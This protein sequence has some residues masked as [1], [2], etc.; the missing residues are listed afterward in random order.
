M[1]LRAVTLAALAA[2]GSVPA[3]HAQSLPAEP[4]SLGD[5]RLVIGAEFTAT[6][7]NKDKGYFNY[8]DYE[9][10]GLR[11]LRLG[12]SAQVRA[13]ERLQVLGELRM[14]Q[15]DVLQPF[16]L[17]VRIRPWP[18][19]RFDIQ[20][21]RI[22]PTFG[23]FSRQVYGASN[24]VIGTPLAYHYLTSLRDDALPVT[25]EDLL[26]MRGRGWRSE[27]P[28]GRR[29]VDRG[30]PLV[31]SVR[32]DT[33][34]QVHGVQGIV[35]WTGALTT[36]SLSN[37][38]VRD[39]NGGRQIAGRMVLRPRASV[40]AGVSAARGAF[41]SDDLTPV[42]PPARSADEGTQSA[43]GAD[44]EYSAGRFLARGEV[45]RSVWRLPLAATPAADWS[46][47]A[48]SVMG[49][50]R[51]RVA[52]GV[53]VAGRVERLGFDRIAATSGLQRWEA[54]VR[55]VEIA[56]GWSIRRNVMAKVA[57]QHNRRDGGRVRRQ[58]FLATQLAY[59]F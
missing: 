30:L 1:L 5:G 44:L 41:L 26:R 13:S 37:P 29:G 48:L 17:Y 21:G 27:Y 24:V 8:T 56:A 7:S 46:L 10:S 31:N 39:D 57:V 38:R 18:A 6:V 54:P 9:Y 20:A 50:A 2:L 22:P 35:E 58:T 51:Y 42:L 12:V 11:N 28:R 53:Q 23:A 32:W 49:E 4:I 40:A 19:R 52:P 15:G 34:V 43:L 55:R 36:G 47:A 3:A 14:D 59:W 45:I 16:A 25:P 33:G